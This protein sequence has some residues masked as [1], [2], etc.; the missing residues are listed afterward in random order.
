MGRVAMLPN[1]VTRCAG[2]IPT[3]LDWNG[4]VFIACVD[5]ERCRRYLERAHGRV[6]SSALRESNDV[7]CAE[8]VGEGGDA[9]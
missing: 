5:R 1:D 7:R 9:V 2:R 3:P 8:F 6:F 4:P